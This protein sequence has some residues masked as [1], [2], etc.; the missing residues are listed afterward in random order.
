MRYEDECDAD[1]SLSCAASGEEHRLVGEA[2][3]QRVFLMY[4]GNKHA[5]ARR[6]DGTVVFDVA[7]DSNVL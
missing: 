6:N 3:Q 4:D 2:G 7:I 1:Q 5:L